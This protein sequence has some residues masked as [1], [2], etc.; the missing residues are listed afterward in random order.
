L[1]LFFHFERIFFK[2]MA[3]FVLNKFVRSGNSIYQG[4]FNA[5]SCIR[6]PA[7]NIFTLIFTSSN[8]R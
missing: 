3:L 7:S 5:F 8:I 4:G 2:V 6:I 1:N